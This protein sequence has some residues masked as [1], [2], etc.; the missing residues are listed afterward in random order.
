ML[1]SKNTKLRRR[2]KR[3]K[4]CLEVVN[5][6]LA[7]AAKALVVNKLIAIFYPRDRKS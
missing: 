3:E 4:N 7:K 6:H 5:R 2:R 1:F